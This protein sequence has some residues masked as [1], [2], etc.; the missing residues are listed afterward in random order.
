MNYF[1]FSEIAKGVIA[2]I[3]SG[4]F[5]ALC[6]ESM[7]LLLLCKNAFLS[8]P[9]HLYQNR[10]R[11]LG[12]AF[13]FKKSRCV[14]FVFKSDLMPELKI[15]LVKMITVS[16]VSE[17]VNSVMFTVG[18]FH[19][20]IFEYIDHSLKPFVVCSAFTETSA[21]R[22]SADEADKMRS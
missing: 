20:Q 10:N 22:V 3:F 5:A 8:L 21:A 9:G 19:K 13:V 4:F 16:F 18:S 6:I 17:T 7:R 12:R 15:K 2:L 14:P 1:S 11:F